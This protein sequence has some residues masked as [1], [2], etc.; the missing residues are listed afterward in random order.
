MKILQIIAGA[1]T[2]GAELFFERLSI[3]INKRNSIEQRVLIRKN[4]TRKNRLK[5]GGVEPVE[6]KFG[7]KLDWQ[8][9]RAI[10]RKIKDFKP[11]IILTWMNRAT[12]MCPA[13]KNGNFVHVARLGGYYDLKYYKTC[14][15][16]IGNTQDL[17]AYLIK[18]KW[19]VEKAHYLPNF[20]AEGVTVPLKKGNYLTPETAPLILAMG[21]LHENKAFDV[22]LQAMVQVPEAYLWIA[23][24]GPLREQLGKVA[25]KMG[26]KSRVRFLS[27]RD[28][29]AALL[30]TADLFVCPSRHEPLGNVVIEA[31]AH[32]TPVVA[33]NSFGPGTLITHL[34]T[35]VLVPIDDPAMLARG[36]KRVLENPNLSRLM[37]E[38]GRDKFEANFTEDIVVDQYIKF[39][40][41]V[42]VP[43][44]V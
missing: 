13:P 1:N 12:S 23:G 21:R 2:G 22:L 33:A 40:E 20:V 9:P 5:A 14:D 44:V 31:W 3:A 10:E 36:I 7:G 16:L 42:T 37:I 27:W 8:T 28:D 4:E 34:E 41:K 18:Q 6:L 26:V 25:E 15:H 39:F 24:D 35:G 19:P 32:N 30:S 11:D 43:C 17:V 29:S 38:R